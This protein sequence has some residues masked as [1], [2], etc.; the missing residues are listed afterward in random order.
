MREIETHGMKY[1]EGTGDI[2][3]IDEVVNSRGYRKAQIGFDVEAREH[4][5]DLGANIGAFAKYCEIRGATCASYEPD[6]D[7]YQLLCQNSPF[8]RI[9]A[10]VS[11]FKESRVDFYQHSNK[12]NHSRGSLLELRNAR[13]HG[14]CPNKY[15]GH[16]KIKYDGIKMD[17]E[18]SEFGI[19]DNNLIP[20][21]NK[22]VLEYH[23]S[24]DSSTVNLQRRLTRLKSLFRNVKYPPEYD[25]AIASGPTFKSFF[26]RLIFCWN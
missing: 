1:R 26:D 8:A 20:K 22:L 19:I 2:R 4:W 18:G 13:D 25:R 15:A 21:C 6:Y 24:R 12:S 16:I 14:S 7:C 11:H 17:I 23:T 10:A 3:I 9:N 5:L